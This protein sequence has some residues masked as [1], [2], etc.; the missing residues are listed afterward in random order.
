MMARDSRQPEDGIAG[1]QTP[2]IHFHL[3]P[4]FYQMLFQGR[5]PRRDL[6]HISGS[7]LHCPSRCS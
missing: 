5:F 1:E 7:R 6:I 3:Q 4:P 2:E